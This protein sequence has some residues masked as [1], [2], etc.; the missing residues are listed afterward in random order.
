MAVVPGFTT[1]CAQ[2]NVG[3]AGPKHPE[4]C[5]TRFERGQMKARVRAYAH[6]EQSG[7]D[8]AEKLPGDDGTRV[9]AAAS[10]TVPVSASVGSA[11]TGS[12]H[13]LGHVQD[14]VMKFRQNRVDRGGEIVAVDDVHHDAAEG[15]AHNV[16]WIEL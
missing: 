1:L 16:A 12:G 11:G 13:D 9:R 8:D 3:L 14:Q 10:K 7:R 2:A 4:P 6:S 15:R 5:L